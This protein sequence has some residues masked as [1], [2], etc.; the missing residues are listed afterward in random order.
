MSQN[1][2]NSAPS[3]SSPYQGPAAGSFTQQSYVSPEEAKSIKTT[4][5]I[6]IV[7]GLFLLGL[8]TTI[9]GIL[10]LTKADEDQVKA[11][12]YLKWGWIIGAI[13]WGIAIILFILMIALGVFAGLAGS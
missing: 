4:S 3:S 6:Q 11:R 12:S 8:P 10:A 7:L 9:L 5:I 2:Y 13:L 1:P